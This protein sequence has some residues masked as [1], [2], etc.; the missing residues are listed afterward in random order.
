MLGIECPPFL[1]WEAITD[2]YGSRYEVGQFMNPDDGLIPAWTKTELDYM[3]GN[4]LEKPDLVLTRRA[5][6][7]GNLNKYPLYYPNKSIEFDNGAEAS[8]QVL[9]FLIENEQLD[10]AKINERY[11]K[12]FQ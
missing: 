4:D 6:K 1:Y 8:A 3:I 7:F 11:I 2:E 9:I 12:F 10:V 5:G